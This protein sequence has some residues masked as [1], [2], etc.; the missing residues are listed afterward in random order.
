M[1]YF[2][3]QIAIAMESSTFAKYNFKEKISCMNGYL[4][5][6]SY[7]FTE[8]GN[9]TPTGKSLLSIQTVALSKVTPIPTVL[10][11]IAIK[12]IEFI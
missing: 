3:L 9:A 10:S 4:G 1:G 2:C 8:I 5:N 11:S 6:H 12:S 7:I